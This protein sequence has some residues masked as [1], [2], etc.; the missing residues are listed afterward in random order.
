MN[1]SLKNT[2][3]PLCK[4][5]LIDKNMQMVVSISTKDVSKGLER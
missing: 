3:Q 4:A 1:Q 2:P 5:Y